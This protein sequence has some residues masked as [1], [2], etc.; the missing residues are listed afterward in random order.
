M[1]SKIQWPCM[2]DPGGTCQH[3]G[4]MPIGAR[5]LS[6]PQD[7]DQLE[8]DGDLVH[9][10]DAA[11]DGITPDEWR[12]SMAL[13]ATALLSQARGGEFVTLPSAVRTAARIAEW[14]KTGELPD[15]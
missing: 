4:C 2:G 14:I 13:H 5:R 9:V 15:A 11:P 8:F 6:V 3:K 7:G 10:M 12:R 1:T